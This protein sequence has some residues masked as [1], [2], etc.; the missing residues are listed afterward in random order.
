[1]G[2]I[3]AQI[4]PPE[5]RLEY[6]L[7]AGQIAVGGGYRQAVLI[8][9]PGEIGFDGL[10]GDGLQ[11]EVAPLYVEFRQG[12]AVFLEGIFGPIIVILLE[13]IQ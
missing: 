11:G 1:M 12:A 2:R 4:A 9:A 6:R 5:S 8:S 7:Q 10:C 13:L 3:V